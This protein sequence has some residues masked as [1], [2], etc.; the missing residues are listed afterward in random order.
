MKSAG[1]SGRTVALFV[2]ERGKRLG[3]GSYEVMIRHLRAA[4]LAAGV[5]MHSFRH[6][7]ATHMLRNGASIV[8]LSKLLGHSYVSTTE[9]YTKVTTDDLQ[10]VL[11]NK[12]PRG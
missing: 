4:G 7:C 6:A 11:K 1:C 8:V 5:T 3:V 2:S 9:I 10:A 12:H